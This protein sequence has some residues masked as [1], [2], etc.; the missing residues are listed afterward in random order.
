MRV[1]AVDACAAIFARIPMTIVDVFLAICAFE[2]LGA[3][4]L[5]LI[6]SNR[7]ALAAVAAGIRIAVLHLHFAVS[8]TVASCTL[9]LEALIGVVAITTVK[10]RFRRTCHRLCLAVSSRPTVFTSTLVPAVAVVRASSI[11]QT[12]VDAAVC[13]FD[14]AV[15]ATIAR[16]TLAGVRSGSGV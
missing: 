10:T 3:L 4:T 11:V 7:C 14:L 5:I 1:D 9:A 8:S 12:R 15:S 2:T 16:R 6:A 13:R